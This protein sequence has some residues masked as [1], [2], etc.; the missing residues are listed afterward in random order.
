MPS[1]GIVVPS[2]IAIVRILSSFPFQGSELM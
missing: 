1:A 2:G